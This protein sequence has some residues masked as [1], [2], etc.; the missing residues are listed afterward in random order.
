M[1]IVF[2]KLLLL[3]SLYLLLLKNQTNQSFQSVDLHCLKNTNK[4]NKIEE[5]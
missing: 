4:L 3:F 1:W 5:V 2:V